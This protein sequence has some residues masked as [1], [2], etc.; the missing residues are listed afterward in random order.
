MKK[1]I[2]SLL[3]IA[4]TLNAQNKITLED[5]WQKY[6]FMPAS[7]DGYNA[8]NDGQNYTDLE[9]VGEMN[10]LVKYSIKTGKKVEILVKGEDVKLNGKTISL[11]TEFD[12]IDRT[13]SKK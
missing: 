10:N 5:I 6:S 1:I 12:A 7:T 13:D 2:I 4:A 9:Q 11:N 3:F 8:M